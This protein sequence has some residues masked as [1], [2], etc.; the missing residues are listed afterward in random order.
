MK[1]LSCFTFPSLD[2]FKKEI[3]FG[4][5]WQNTV[6]TRGKKKMEGISEDDRFNP[7][8][9]TKSKKRNYPLQYA[10]KELGHYLGEPL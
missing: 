2:V 1:H 5:F 10:P 4:F 6:H 7:K 8:D 3:A 9:N